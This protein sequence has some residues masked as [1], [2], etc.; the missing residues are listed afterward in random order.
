MS[1][2]ESIDLKEKYK[3]I[4][5]NT[6]DL[7]AILNDKFEHEFINE[8]AYLKVLGY[9]KEDIIGKRPR[10]FSHPEDIKR[11]SRAIKNG[12]LKG[13][14]LAEFRIRHKNGYYIWVETKG[15]YLIENNNVKGIIFISRDISKRK[16]AEHKLLELNK[17]KSEFLKKTSHE[18]KTPLV[19]IKGFSD[20]ILELYK[21]QLNSDIISKLEDIIKS[22]N[23]LQN[24]INN[25]LKTSKLESPDFKLIIKKEDL[26]NLIKICVNELKSLSDAKI[27][28][29]DLKINE[30]I[31]VELEKGEIHDVILNLLTNAIKYTPPRGK[32][33]VKTEVN[34]K[35]VVV[36]IK[37]NGIGFTESEKKKIFKQ[38]GKIARYEQDV[39]IEIEG[40]GLGLYISKKIIESHGGKIWMESEGRNKGSIFYFS[41][42]L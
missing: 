30:N 1:P 40:T 39:D 7:I 29:I 20:L 27:Q 42:P 38:Y 16:E 23:R 5:D 18:L 33:E 22:C 21:D 37:D 36:S 31:F 34:K 2:K 25:L 17:L 35:E 32:I 26:S 10:D 24:I 9:S 6:E 8:K 4:L 13:K 14:L 28:S 3:L 15:N 19:S 12:L 41:L 11:I